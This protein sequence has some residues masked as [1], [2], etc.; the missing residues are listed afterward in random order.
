MC[1]R[2]ALASTWA[3]R[4][5]A[6]SAPNGRVSSRLTPPVSLSFL[7]VPP[8]LLLFPPGTDVF[9]HHAKYMS[10]M[11]GLVGLPGF[12]A[13]CT[14]GG[15]RSVLT[16]SP[17]GLDV[18]AKTPR[19]RP[20]QVNPNFTALFDHPFLFFVRSTLPDQPQVLFAAVISDVFKRTDFSTKFPLPAEWREYKEQMGQNIQKLYAKQL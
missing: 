8:S 6:L 14:V 19:V 4:T 10:L 13:D 9:S 17:H 2:C 7:C 12:T 15:H 16:L 18:G 20:G 5:H 3:A 11:S 1:G